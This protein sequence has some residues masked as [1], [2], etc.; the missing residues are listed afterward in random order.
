MKKTMILTAA[1]LLSLCVNP[2]WAKEPKQFVAEFFKGVKAGKVNQAYD[3]LLQGSG[4]AQA[5]PQDVDVLKSQT[6]N[7]V[8][9]YGPILDSEIVREEKFGNSIVRLVYILKHEK[10][11]IIWQFYFYRPHGKWFLG[12]IDFN[13]QFQNLEKTQ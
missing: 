8:S 9:F 7:I 2:A 4:I 12:K 6:S 13:D 3:G 11:P 5:K 1:V 10:G